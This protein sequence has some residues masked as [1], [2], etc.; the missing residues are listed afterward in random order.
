MNNRSL[1]TY[2]MRYRLI[3]VGLVVALLFTTCFVN[4]Q[5]VDAGS[6]YIVRVGLTD[7]LKAQSSVKIDTKKIAMG[8]CINNKFSEYIHMSSSNGFTVKPATGYYLISDSV[9]STYSKVNAAY[10]KAKKVSACKN[11][12]YICMLGKN[13]WALYVGGLTDVKT[14]SAWESKLKSAGVSFASPT[15]YN[16]HRVL[17]SGGGETYMF[18]G[19]ESGQYVQ[20]VANV[21]NKKG[22]K[23]LSVGG[24]E[25]RGRMEIGPY[26][27]DTLTVVNIC[28]VENYLRSVVGSEMDSSYPV[29]AL[30]AQAVVSRTYAEHYCENYGD[31]N[32]E[33]PY[34]LNDTETYQKYGGY[35]KENAKCVEAV[36]TTRG[37]CIYYNGEQ[38]DA[39][40]FPSSGG[41][42]ES[43][44]SVR[45]TSDSYLK[46]VSD[47]VDIAYGNK[48]WT[49]TYSKA[50]LAKLVGLD[51][52][53]SL[54]VDTKSTTGRALQVSIKGTSGG[55]EK[56]EKLRG[57]NVRTRLNLPSTKFKMISVDQTETVVS[58]MNTE[59]TKTVDSLKNCYALN[60]SGTPVSLNNGAS[61]YVVMSGQNLTNYMAQATSDSENFTFV[62]L[63]KGHG[64]GMSQA[65]ARA[66]AQR[67]KSYTDIIKN[68]Y[69]D[70]V[71][72]K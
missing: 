63:G 65:G 17:I 26:G 3:A 70:K 2:K 9:Y 57:D 33:Q 30:R 16:G 50:D 41:I 66:M 43:A 49:V 45:G 53:E 35:S 51:E 56:T 18:D 27:T 29:E 61:Q 5:R 25:Y 32:V 15:S 7:K 42:T 19:E 8:Y 23:T 44:L 52:V 38:I 14:V 59:E 47:L 54:T 28:N 67:G 37:K 34:I 55:K 58:V 48:P 71:S 40:F 64:M 31:T 13:Q 62:G 11:N 10:K 22:S 39:L 72:I 24:T 6:L 1:K 4:I 12:V 69:G 20:I 36:T 60:A 68:Y 46:S 21:L